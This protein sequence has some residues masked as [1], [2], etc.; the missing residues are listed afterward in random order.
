MRLKKVD[1]ILLLTGTGLIAV[2]IVTGSCAPEPTPPQEATEDPPISAVAPAQPVPAPSI[3]TEAPEDPIGLW[4]TFQTPDTENMSDEMRER[5]EALE[6]IGYLAGYDDAPD[7]NG[8]ICYDDARAWNGYNLYNSG[9]A[10][11]AIL[12]DMPGNVLHTW[13]CD[14]KDAFPDRYTE[15][16]LRALPLLNMFRRVHLLD[17][18]DLLAIYSG[19]GLI[20]LDKDSNLLWASEIAAQHDLHVTKNGRIFVLTHA[21]RV[22]PE[23]QDTRTVVEDFVTIL[24]E[25]GNELRQLSLYE[26]FKNSPFAS[27]LDRAR[28]ALDN[29]KIQEGDVFHT[30]T[31]HMFDGSLAHVSD[32]LKEG[33]ML[34][35]WVF[36]QTLFIVDGDTGLVV[37]AW[38]GPWRKGIHEPSLLANGHLLLFINRGDKW[39]TSQVCEYDFLTRQEVWRYCGSPEKPE[40]EFL[41]VTCGTTMRL[42]NGNTLITST[43]NGRAIEVTPDKDVVWEFFN[44]NRAGD[45]NE[46]IASLFH[47]ERLPADFPLDWLESTVEP[48]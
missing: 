42:P 9:H 15:E 33:N 45:N 22:I 46:L 20:R 25:G 39:S 44:P 29:P 37:W 28:A 19:N 13:R 43:N 18:G 34:F 4:H 35:A 38:H 8:V 11:E 32:V 2:A 24:S 21:P 47:D 5:M 3:P 30:N 10:A 16:E 17:N 1:W 23:F 7:Q 31:L 14:Y 48:E 6:A 36:L 40:T 27:H 41:S 26:A 12:M